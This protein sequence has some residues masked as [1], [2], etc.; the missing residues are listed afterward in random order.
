MHIDID[1][2]LARYFQ[3]LEKA[4]IIE[5]LF[6]SMRQSDEYGQGDIYSLHSLMPWR[7]RLDIFKDLEDLEA[8]GLIKPGKVGFYILNAEKYF[9]IMSIEAEKD[10][11]K[12]KA[13]LASR[14]VS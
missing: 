12:M 2:Y 4:V 8:C 1:M 13:F 3:S 10:E 11:V 14:G 5:A 9:E 6:C 7:P